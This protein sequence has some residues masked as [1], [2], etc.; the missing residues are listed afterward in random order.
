MP[1]KDKNKARSAARE[2]YYKK[3]DKS[4][5]DKLIAARIAS[6]ALRCGHEG[7]TTIL[8]RYNTEEYCAIHAPAYNLMKKQNY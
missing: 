1:Y 6:G 5:T 8:S 3:R 2:R 4:S 7:C